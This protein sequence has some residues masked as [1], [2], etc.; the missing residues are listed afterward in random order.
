[1]TYPK[2]PASKNKKIEKLKPAQFYL[3]QLGSLAKFHTLGI[4][5]KLRQENIRVHHSLTKENIGGQLS[6]AEYLKC[7]HLLIIGQKE[8]IEKS[9]VVRS[10]EVREQETVAM[11]ELT[12]HLKKLLKK[13]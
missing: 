10:M 13:L 2:Q 6:S 9:V 4:I 12:T 11:N 7:S 3:V 5:E 8:A 1:M